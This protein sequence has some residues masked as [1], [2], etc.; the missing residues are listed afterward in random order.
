MDFKGAERSVL[1]KLAHL[2][3]HGARYNVNSTFATQHPCIDKSFCARLKRD[4]YWWAAPLRPG[5]ESSD[6]FR[7]A[8]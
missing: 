4:W 1:Q 8:S 5:S 3:E 6:H 2:L 7:L